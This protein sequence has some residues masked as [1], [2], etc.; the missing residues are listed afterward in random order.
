MPAQDKHQRTEAPTPKRR[1]E[2]RQRGQV[3]RSVDVAG[4]A[5]VAVSSFLVPWF[6]RLVTGQVLAVLHQATGVF[7]RP[8]P[9]AA[10][11]VLE[12]GLKV[13]LVSIAPLGGILA[14]VAIVANI[15][16]TGR[17]FSFQAARPKLSR[18]SPREG[19]RRLVS[20]QN[21]VQLLK[22]LV[23]LLLLV[24]VGYQ[25]IAGIVHEMVDARPVSLLPILAVTGANVL[26]FI[27]ILS[28]LGLAVGLVDFVY[29]RRKLNDQ[30]KM[31]KQEVKE[32]SKAA[33]GDPHL[34][35]MVRK[36]MYQIARTQMLAAVRTADV[37]VTNPTHYAVAL[38]YDATRSAAPRVVA[39]G[40]DQLAQRIREEAATSEIPV[41][42][43]PPLARYLYAVC[44]VDETIPGEIF[45]AV[46]RLLAF[47]YSLPA[48]LRGVGV[49][50]LGAS[51]LPAEPAALAKLR[52]G[53]RARAEAVLA[54]TVAT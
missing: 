20:P 33:E 12:S 52:D 8:T 51:I 13:I 36:R 10:L 16:Q 1:R 54:G 27:R 14:L 29:Q 37:V 25:A 24:G 34:K 6:L 53:Q 9:Q 49:H 43:D 15:A 21:G 17:A 19:I 48:T 38:R 41:V 7:A 28:L 3:A 11:R 30:L 26:S 18:I 4:W 22:Q 40:S 39:K 23:K 31:T 46:A 47:V 50:H 32:E 44:D 2:A 42:E 5:G 35:G 45:V